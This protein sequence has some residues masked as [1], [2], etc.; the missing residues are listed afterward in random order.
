MM[1]IVQRVSRAAV[2]RRTGEKLG[3]IGRGLVVLLCAEVGDDVEHAQ[4]MIRRLAGLR[5]F[6]DADGRMNLDCRQVQ[7]AFLVISQFT[8]AAD[9][10]RGHRPS[11]MGAA[12]PD[13]AA[14]LVDRV[15]AGLRELG[16]T[17]ECGAFGAAMEVELVN[18]GP[19]T[20][21]LRSR[22]N[23]LSSAGDQR[24]QSQK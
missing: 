6:E 13:V 5:I 18:D 3:A 17:V 21:P 2:R 15:G 22:E 20:I 14:P 4:W 24:S 7:G 11:F 10:R 8:L 12:L 23:A 19:V 9:T 1:A 16:F